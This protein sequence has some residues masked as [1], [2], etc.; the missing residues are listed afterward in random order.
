MEKDIV[1]Y[2]PIYHLIFEVAGKAYG[3]DLNRVME[4]VAL[5]AFKP[6]PAI[7]QHITGM[8][9]RAGWIIPVMDLRRRFEQDMADTGLTSI[10][11]VRVLGDDGPVR[12]AIRVDAVKAFCAVSS[13]KMETSFQRLLQQ[14]TDWDFVTGKIRVGD[15]PVTLLDI[16]LLFSQNE[17]ARLPHAA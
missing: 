4:I 1:R 11:V 14:E 8:I 10:V 15:Y 16:D 13:P 6:V 2:P 5:R 9:E 12:K 17:A 7:E 3:I